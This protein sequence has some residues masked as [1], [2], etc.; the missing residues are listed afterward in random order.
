MERKT[1]LFLL[2]MLALT[3]VR[4]DFTRKMIARW[5]FNSPD[6]AKVM[7]DDSGKYKL[8]EAQKFT[9]AKISFSKGIISVNES[10]MLAAPGINSTALPELT[11]DVTVWARLK[12]TGKPGRDCFFLGLLNADKSADWKQQ[13][14]SM[15][16]GG[17]SKMRLFGWQSD[18]KEFG[19]TAPDE[20]KKAKGFINIAL[21]Y[22]E[23]KKTA[24]V[25]VNGKA[26][27]RNLK[28]SSLAPFKSLALGRLKQHSAVSFELDELRIYGA[29]IPAEWLS[30]IEPVE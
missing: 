17:D 29:S 9:G 24:T 18:K 4:A 22:S 10:V 6:R 5:T 14:L 23:A 1:S 21:V 7:L 16:F 12:V 2:S 26:A 15:M 19:V 3:S 20:Y 13:T 8:I 25:Y 11:K 27:S 30:E 28:A